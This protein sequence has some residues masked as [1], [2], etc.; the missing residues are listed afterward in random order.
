MKPF[1]N[2]NLT[3]RVH[4]RPKFRL[5]LQV[6]QPHGENKHQADSRGDNQQQTGT[7]QPQIISKGQLQTS[8]K[9]NT[10]F[11]L[12]PI[13]FFSCD[14]IVLLTVFILTRNHM[15]FYRAVS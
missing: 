14:V 12:I 7:N 8:G 5:P 1:Q 2:P 10:L 6:H 3:N 11:F 15:L 4:V 9:K 13:V